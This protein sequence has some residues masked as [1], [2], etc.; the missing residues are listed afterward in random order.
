[1]KNILI[2]LLGIF[3]LLLAIKVFNISIP[4]NVV[5]TSRTNELAVVGEGKI[6]IVPD[7]AYVNAGISVNNAA[8]V[9]VA[10]KSID[11]INNKILDGVKKLGI[12]K[13]DL[14]TTNYSINPN[15]DKKI[16]SYD[17]NASISIKAKN[18]AIVPQIIEAVTKAGANQVGGVEYT[19]NDPNSFREQVR[20]KAIQNA[21]V[22]AEK[23]AKTLGI[24]LGKITNI[25]ESSPNPLPPVMMRS[26]DSLRTVGALEPQIEPGTQTLTSTV[27]LY[28]EKE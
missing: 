11:D 24:R 23:L 2:V 13:E 16:Q 26:A 18:I 19:V 7:T 17:G 25:V 3:V 22:E 4:L 15:Y 12:K 28:F 5:S 27:T 1:M 14:K 6:D 8:T 10:K 9:D 20:D 21:K